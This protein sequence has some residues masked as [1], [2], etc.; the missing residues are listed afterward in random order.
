MS[1]CS[2]GERLIR[3]EPT[4]VILPPMTRSDIDYQVRVTPPVGSNHGDEQI[5]H[6]EMEDSL[7]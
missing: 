3:F 6:A 7:P 5:R 2:K 4:L 1:G